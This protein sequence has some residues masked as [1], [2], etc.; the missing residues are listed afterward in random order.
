MTTMLKK[1]KFF[2]IGL[3][4]CIKN[5]NFYTFQGEGLEFSKVYS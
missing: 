3:M 4:K 5:A 1:I 2:N